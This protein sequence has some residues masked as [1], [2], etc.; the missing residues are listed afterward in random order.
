MQARP[1]KYIA[2]GRYFVMVFFVALHPEEAADDRFCRL[3]EQPGK[4]NI[5]DYKK[6]AYDLLPL[7]GGAENIS[8]LTHCATRLRF[9]FCDR[10]IVD[11]PAIEH[12]QGVISVVDKGGQFQVVVGNDV[13]ITYRALINEMG[14]TAGKASNGSGASSSEKEDKPSVINRIISVISTTFT[15]VI[16]ALIGGGMIKAVLSILVLCG[17]DDS[18]STYAIMNLISDAA[19]YF[20]PV[21]LAYGAA[22][23]F[24]CNPVLAMTLACAL[25]HPTWTGMVGAGESIDFFHIPVKLVDYSYSVIPIILSIWIMSYVEKFAEKYTPSIIKFFLKP[26]IILFI[27]V[28]IA[29]VIVGPFGSFLNSV[30]ESAANAINARASWLLPMLM[31]A[32]QPFLV[33]TGTAWAMTPIATVQIS[34]LG[35]E[36]VN[37]PGMLASNIAQGGATLAVAVKTKNKQLKQLASSSGFT[38]VM[39]ITEPCLY[40]VT[41]KLKKP[42]IASMIG[43]G[44]GGIYAGLSGLVR[45]AFVSPGLAALPAFIGENPMNIVHAVITC[46]ISFVAAFIAAWILGF[47]DPA[48]TSTASVPMDTE[49]KAPISAEGKT[50]VVSP[51][52]GK[53]VSLSEVNDAVFSQK[54]LGDGIA[55]QPSDGN[56]YA[57][58]DGKV[59]TLFDT[60][61]AIGLESN[62][63]VE[64]LIHIGIDTVNLEGKHFTAHVGNGDTVKKGDLLVSFDKSA[65]EQEGYDTVTPVLITNTGDFRKIASDPAHDIK[66]GEL[67]LTLS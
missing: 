38:A 5:M 1:H 58:V 63:G 49:K 43:G 45:Y 47:E 61:H 12:T 31:G 40:G 55:I 19:F 3:P 32:F 25:L 48:D 64:I 18:S 59:T 2:V 44:I 36:I 26:L 22:I 14:G 27:S 51:L 57:P 66:A 34:S 35:Y 11:V 62:D 65:I 4:G 10:S 7:V 67:L 52:C 30:V 56:V 13:P 37:G 20:M 46:I 8:K 17:L 21:L 9:E 6:L 42:L 41:L 39:G 50:M 24:E 33:L 29:L 53:T 54:V 15:P 60:K 23:K 16:P 28:P